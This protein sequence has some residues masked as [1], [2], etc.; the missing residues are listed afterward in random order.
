MS[1]CSLLLPMSPRWISLSLYLWSA[2]KPE[3]S[4]S[5]N[6]LYYTTPDPQIGIIFT[7]SSAIF[8]LAC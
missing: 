8:Y 4:L 2:L 7:D 3:N 1:F 6:L 5:Q